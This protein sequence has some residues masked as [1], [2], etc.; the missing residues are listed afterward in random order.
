MSA[1]LPFAPTPLRPRRGHLL[2]AITRAALPLVLI[3]IYLH[4]PVY[5]YTMEKALLPKYFYM[6][7]IALLMPVLMLRLSTFISYLTS[8]FVIW[9]AA[10]LALDLVHMLSDSGD[11]GVR[12]ANLVAFR[13]QAG[14]MVIVLGFVFS[15]HRPESYQRTFVLLSVIL[16]CTVIADF[17]F[18]GMLYPLDTPGA[19]LGRASGTFINPT[20]AG[21][22]ILLS[23]LLACPA[24]PRH[25]RTPLIL[26]AGIAVLLTF[27]R[28]AMMAWLLL[29]F[30]LMAK[31]RL[32]AFGT[33]VALGVVA[34]PLLMGGL[35]SYL[36]NRKDFDSAL[37]NIQ[38][39]LSF[40]SAKSR[41]DDDSA[42]ERSEVLLAGWQL[43]LDNPITG[44]GAGA[45]DMGET[46]I[47]PHSVS[48]HN[49]L[50]S[51]AAEYGIP[52]IVM[53]CWLLI[54]MLRGRHFEDRVFKTGFI[55]LFVM[56][57]FFT[58]NMMDFPYWLLTFALLSHRHAH[59][60]G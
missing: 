21:E 49:Q 4:L 13:M 25:Y 20:I 36:G 58:H 48:T 57:S 14:A 53:W 47:W 5:A 39:R 29:W 50:I 33:V 54:L 8:P 2:A 32:P 37:E 12:N 46:R 55:M 35:Q 11:S 34:L 7:F 1:V 19:V 15:L 9:M 6:L 56:M 41:L 10:L 31:R 44:A 23:F 3:I 42:R 45:T 59:A 43:F 17:L 22:A 38:T 28:A 18:P 51:L 40:F 52:G 30:Y 16:P 27:T 24:V 60:G 26:L